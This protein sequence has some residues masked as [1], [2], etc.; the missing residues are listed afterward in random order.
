MLETIKLF[1]DILIPRFIT[2]KVVFELDENHELSALC[3]LQDL[4]H[5]ENVD[6]FYAVGVVKSFN[7][8]GLSTFAR[9]QPETLVYGKN[10]ATKEKL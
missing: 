6:D 5:Y 3:C 10:Y 1:L 8:L 7:I 2:E 4:R 9:L